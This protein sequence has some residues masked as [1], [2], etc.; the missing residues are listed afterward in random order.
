M[1][2]KQ[3]LFEV[4]ERLNPDFKLTPKQIE[5]HKMMD[6]LKFIENDLPIGIRE[7][8]KELLANDMAG[9]SFPG[10]IILPI[11]Q[12]AEEVRE[13][14]MSYQYDENGNMINEPITEFGAYDNTVEYQGE[15]YNAILI[16]ND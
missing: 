13:Y 6:R 4:M 14:L 11:T 10:L 3:R 1:D 7:Y 2:N 12:E 15:K 8:V 5:H 9:M 16:N